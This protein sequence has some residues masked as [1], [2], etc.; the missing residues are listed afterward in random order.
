MAELIV[1]GSSASVPDADHDTVG[2]ALR[3][4]DW[5]ILI[6]CGGSPVQ[7]LAQ[8]GIGL[9]E[10]E[11]L[12]LSHQH[13]DHIYGLP[14]LVQG[15]W[16]GGRE[17]PLP[18]YGPAQALD[19]AKALLELLDLSDREGMFPVEWH[20]VPLREGREVGRWGEILISAAPMVHG[21]ND[22]L[23]LRFENTD[24][25]RAAV[26]SAD[27]EPCAALVRLAAG[28]DLL[29]HEAT[30]EHPGHS[31]PAEA[32]EVAREAGVARL[33]LIH[34][35]VRGVNLEAWRLQAAEFPGPVML[36]R[37]GDRYEL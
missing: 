28:A 34:Y 29:L 13:T 15:L 30:G 1:L 3:G 27:T 36:A 20:P 31:T 18:I 4:S 6:E 32:A 19:R 7:K 24:T 25:G 2:L 33:A 26:Y 22:T 21:S 10:L 12:V 23:A 9:E 16:I 17:N 8:L 37:E 14:A 5:A 11:A 35:P